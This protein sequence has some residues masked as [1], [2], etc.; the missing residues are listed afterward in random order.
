MKKTLRA[1]FVL[2]ISA[3]MGVAIVGGHARAQTY[4][5]HGWHYVGTGPIGVKLHDPAYL[6][7][8]ESVYLNGSGAGCANYTHLIG[9]KIS[10]GSFGNEVF[11]TYVDAS[12]QYWLYQ[13]HWCPYVNGNANSGQ[14]VWDNSQSNHGLVLYPCST[15][16]NIDS[17][18]QQGPNNNWYQ[19]INRYWQKYMNCTQY[20]GQWCWD[21]GYVSK[22]ADWNF[23][24]Y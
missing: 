8:N 13:A 9:W 21:G 19:L 10:H 5:P 14:C 12:G 18:Y 7:N 6:Y 11:N 2:T 20:D 1:L 22:Q 16:S 15:A 24:A 4:V 3:L 23:V 17:F